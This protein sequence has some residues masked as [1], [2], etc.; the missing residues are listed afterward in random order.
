MYRVLL[1]VPKTCPLPALCWEL[2]GIQMKYRVIMKKLL[3]LW[4]L[5]NLEEGSL[6]K[7][8]L[9]VQKTQ[10]LPGL[11]QEC[12]DYMMTL[13]LP[14]PFVVKM[15]KTQW[16]NKVKKSI[17]KENEEDLRKKMMKLEKLKNSELPKQKCETKEYI[18]TLSISDARHI[19]KKN[20]SMTRYVKLN[21]MHDIQYVKDLWQCDSCQ[22]KIDSMKHV[23]WCPS[24][25][26]LRKDRNLDDDQDLAKY[27]HEVMTIRSKLNLQK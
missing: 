12:K 7:E 20:T 16:K 9:Q 18:K 8:V 25:S 5:N 26:E 3:F 19:F 24:Y 2:G 27:L 6:A 23:L 13:N 11:V 21:Y 15:S 1:N 10:N 4:H 14:D 17:Q 22:R